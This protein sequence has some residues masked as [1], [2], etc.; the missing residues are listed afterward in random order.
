MF[1]ESF[2]PLFVLRFHRPVKPAVAVRPIC[3]AREPC[4]HPGF[5]ADRLG[6]Y[7]C[8][9]RHRSVRVLAV[10]CERPKRDRPFGVHSN[11]GDFFIDA[12]SKIPSSREPNIVSAE[13]WFKRPSACYRPDRRRRRGLPTADQRRE[14]AELAPPALPI[15]LSLRH[16]ISPFKIAASACNEDFAGTRKLYR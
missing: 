10:R 11:H 5:E 9:I 7:V 14:N 4:R 6:M 13:A 2:P 16:H 1:G 8:N 3:H 12:L 15:P